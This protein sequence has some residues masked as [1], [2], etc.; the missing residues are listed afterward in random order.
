VIV[1]GFAVADQDLLHPTFR[2]EQFELTF[3]RRP[4]AGTRPPMG[5]TATWPGSS[6]PAVLADIHQL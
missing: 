2:N 4:V 1:D 5:I 6:E 3:H